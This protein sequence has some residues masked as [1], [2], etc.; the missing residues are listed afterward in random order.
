MRQ[1]PD[2]IVI[3]AARSGTTAIHGYLR[4]SQQIFMPETKEPNFFA[5]AGEK[6]TVRGPGA[7]FINN[8]I[9]DHDAYRAL[10]KD[11]P[12]NVFLGEA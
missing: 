4:Q 7:E 8:S 6:L 10:F 12:E 3:G 1:I 5:Y 9:T 11:A 2:F